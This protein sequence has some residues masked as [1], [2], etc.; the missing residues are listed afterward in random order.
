MISKKGQNAGVLIIF[1]IIILVSFGVVNILSSEIF[2]EITP[3]ITADLNNR[4]ATML[5]DLEDRH[6]SS[7]D[8]LFVLLLI[9]FTI[10][11]MV[12]AYFSDEHPILLM[13]TIII[14][15]FALLVGAIFSNFWE[16]FTD[17]A[18]ITMENE[19][20]MTNFILDN[21]VIYLLSL[22]VL[23]IGTAFIRRG[24]N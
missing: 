17:D 5:T 9:L 13:V 10:F 18:N 4:S 14:L 3:E 8:G 20:P 6:T 7:L 1:L 12:V 24:V 2:A 11:L 19:M 21:L 16:E 15:I 23:L 22:G